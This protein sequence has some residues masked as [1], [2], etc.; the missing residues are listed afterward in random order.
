MANDFTSNPLVIDSTFTNANFVF[1]ARTYVKTIVWSKMAAGDRLVFQDRNGK[2]VLDIVSP[3]N[4][5]IPLS[6][7]IC[8]WVNGLACTQID[9][10]L[11]H[12]F[13]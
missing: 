9:S 2:T 10:G 3:L 5:D 12:I 1:K 6:Q 7:E 8:T 11:V 13:I 4:N